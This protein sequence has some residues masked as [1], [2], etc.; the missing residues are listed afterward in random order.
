MINVTRFFGDADRVFCLSDPMIQELERLSGVGI[1]TI[2]QRA[3][4][5]QFKLDDLTHTLRLALIGGGTSPQD[6]AQLVDTWAQNRP[7]AETFPLALD[8]LDARWN[9]ITQ[10]QPE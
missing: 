2:Y 7:F 8:V 1:G 5:Q 3:I 4:A 6:A 9:G 10:E